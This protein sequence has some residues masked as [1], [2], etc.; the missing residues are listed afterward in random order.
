MNKGACCVCGASLVGKRSNAETCSGR[1][2]LQRL[3]DRKSLD[4][5]PVRWS[6]EARGGPSVEQ[7]PLLIPDLDITPEIWKE[8]VLCSGS[9]KIRQRQPGPLLK[10][11]NVECHQCGG[12]GKIRCT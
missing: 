1:C 10:L 8:C 5:Y 11:V 9:G 12:P 7:T 3:R 6:W 2:R 4:G